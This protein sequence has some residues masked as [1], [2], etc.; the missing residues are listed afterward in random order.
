MNAKLISFLLQFILWVLFIGTPIA[1]N[2][3][4]LH[5]DGALRFAGRHALYIIFFYS[6]YFYFIP[7]IL[8]QKGLM[9]YLVLVLVSFLAV[10]VLGH[11]MEGWLRVREINSR[12][13]LG[14]VPLIQ[15]YAVSTTFRLTLD[16]IQQLTTQKNLEEQNRLA[17]INFLRSQINPHFLFNTLNNI[18]A[19][20]R[21][22][23]T[24]AERSI[25]TLSDLMRYMLSTSKLPKVEL[26]KEI[27]Y[28][29]NYIELQ[30][31]R[32]DKNFNIKCEV[33]VT[34]ETVLIEP[35][36]LIGF[37][38]NTFKH[39]V[40]GSE[41]D[42]IE[43]KINS[44]SDHLELRARNKMHDLKKINNVISGVGLENTKKRLE[45]CYKNKYSIE[46]Q[47]TDDIYDVCFKLD[48]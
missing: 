47:T 40:S 21:L 38:E 37:I 39:G 27:S 18:N 20:I 10:F 12:L 44:A 46:L 19:L 30:K 1:N 48:L 22:R 8:K 43:V 7:K 36:L 3:D 32:L 26:G 23:P 13:F 34:N 31:L 11:I 14:L 28:I 2:P 24:E 15:V 16:Y 4:H 41:D 33:S 25:G 35:L 5:G 17:E 6:N 9:S 29:H 45:L 42:F